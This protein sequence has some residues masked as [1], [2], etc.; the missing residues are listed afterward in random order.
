MYLHRSTIRLTI[1]N[2]NHHRDGVDT[3]AVNFAN[4]KMKREVKEE[5]YSM[6]K[7][8]NASSLL[9]ILRGTEVTSEM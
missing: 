9:E 5:V 4:F 8:F 3:F 1:S 2:I 7:Q 6:F